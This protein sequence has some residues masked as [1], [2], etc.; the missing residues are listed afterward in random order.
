MAT[1][2]HLAVGARGCSNPP[3]P[4]QG[5]CPARSGH[6]SVREM[7]SV[8]LA[9]G[10]YVHL[11][12]IV[13]VE[14][15]SQEPNRDTVAEGVQIRGRS[16]KRVR[17]QRRSSPSQCSRQA[18]VAVQEAWTRPRKR[19]YAGGRGETGVV[20][21]QKLLSLSAQKR[22]TRVLAEQVLLRSGRLV[23]R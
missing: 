14:G 12:D 19:S 13:G 4:L 16:P 17:P 9:G 23:R 18:R 7:W 21:E 6:G 10:G 20:Q 11:A 2:Y 15:E 22:A 3:H 5:T 8:R 1:G